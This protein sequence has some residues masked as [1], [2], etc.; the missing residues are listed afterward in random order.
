MKSALQCGGTKC[1][2]KVAPATHEPPLAHL[3]ESNRWTV[4]KSNRR[5]QERRQ[6]Q[7]AADSHRQETG[8]NA[9]HIPPLLRR[10]LAKDV[11]QIA[12]A[13]QVQVAGLVEGHAFGLR[14]IVLKAVQTA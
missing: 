12:L 1:N 5:V 13:D 11:E 2:V 6:P 10:H 8:C 3:R 7:T 14:N 9:S 4:G